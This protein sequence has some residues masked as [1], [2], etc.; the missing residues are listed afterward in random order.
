VL[1][2]NGSTSTWTKS[3]TIG[4]VTG[5]VTVTTQIDGTAR[6][7]YTMISSGA[8]VKSKKA[9]SISINDTGNGDAL[10]S[11]WQETTPP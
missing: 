4:T 5:N 7:S 1:Q 9:I 2:G 10:F 8:I 11:N 6:G 3:Y